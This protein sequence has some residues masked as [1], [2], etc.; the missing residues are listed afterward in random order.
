MS[1]WKSSGKTVYVITFK[2]NDTPHMIVSKEADAD[3]FCKNH[4]NYTWECWDVQS[5]II[6]LSTPL[7]RQN[8]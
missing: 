8:K 1:G 5:R 4:P 7:K 3:D 2:S 6:Q